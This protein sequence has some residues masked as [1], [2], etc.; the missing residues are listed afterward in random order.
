VPA[1]DSRTV[2][3]P[4]RLVLFDLDD[5]LFDHR[6]S[7]EVALRG[8]RRAHPALRRVAWTDQLRRYDELL[9]ETHREVMAGTLTPEAA[10]EE[11]FR[12]LFLEAG[13]DAGSRVLRAVATT[14][15][16]R[17]QASRRA[18]RGARAL[19]ASYRRDGVATG[20]VTNNLLAEQEDK[21]TAIRLLPLVSF[22]VTSEEVGHSKPA[23][24]IFRE[25]LDRA[26]VPAAE[27]R[28]VGDSWEADIRG[29]A[30][31]GIPAIWYNPRGRSRPTGPPVPEISSF[32]PLARVRRT[33]AEAG[34]PTPARAPPA[35]RPK[36]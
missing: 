23:P 8:A 33:I 21:L 20:I 18:A 30:A 2:P 12:R 34:G 19:L 10:R 3:S 13:T 31:A 1:P 6:G 9:A 16:D 7:L 17:Y 35:R 24:E 11:R 29:A 28:M 32:S 22:L 25:A 4:P 26:R 14:Y 27:A 5:T 15:R 36:G